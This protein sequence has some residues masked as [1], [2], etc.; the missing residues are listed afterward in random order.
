MSKKQRKPKIK[1]VIKTKL[2]AG[3]TVMVVAGGN[4]KGEALKGQTGKILKVSKDSPRATVQGLN[5]IKKHKKALRSDDSSGIITKEGGIHLSN[6]MFYSEQI[7]KPVRL[8]YKKLED[9]KKVRGFINPE[10]KE[11]Q[12]IES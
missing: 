1:A 8:K 12:Q 5:M 10:S 9:G 6:L 11:F 4:K 2:K 7:S 3:D